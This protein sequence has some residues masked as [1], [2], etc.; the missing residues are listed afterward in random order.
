VRRTISL[1]PFGSVS[2]D[3]SLAAVGVQTVGGA[4]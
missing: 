2:G 1:K 4:R 3:L